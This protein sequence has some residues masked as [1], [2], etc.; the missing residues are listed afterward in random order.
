MG[1]PYGGVLYEW[2]GK[3]LPFI[4]LALLALAD[5]S[6]HSL[7]LPSILPLLPG[8]Q[9]LVLQPKVDRGEPEGSTI[10]QLAKDPYIIVA[11]GSFPENRLRKAL[12]LPYPSIF[13]NKTSTKYTQFLTDCF[14]FVQSGVLVIWRGKD[15]KGWPCG[16]ILTMSVD[17]YRFQ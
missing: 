3:E 11:A 2:S 10:K 5:G 15:C 17:D 16:S 9:F 13:T 7:S 1:P 4:L 6:T 14:S 8:M 12:T